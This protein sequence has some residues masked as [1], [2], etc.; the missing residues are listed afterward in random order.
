[1]KHHLAIFGLAV[2]TASG[3]GFAQQ[4][5]DAPGNPRGNERV[6]IRRDFAPPPP[7]GRRPPMER[8]F[9][10]MP[11]GGRWW[12]N[13]EIQ[14]KLN[15]T[16]D[17][18]KKMDDI[19]QQSRIKLIYMNAS[20]Q[21]AEVTLEPMMSSDQPDEA[22]IIAQIDKIAEARAELEKQNARMLL[23]LRSTLTLE[24][25]KKVQAIAPGPMM[26]RERGNVFYQK[27]PG[28]GGPGA[29]G[30]REDGLPPGAPR[31]PEE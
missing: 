17:Q 18:Q 31:P 10:I 3:L 15:L 25:W 4:T 6:I 29:G 26:D 5:P 9:R 7:E 30:L 12:A 14:Q 24:Q 16:V 8:S 27:M 22:K 13:P 2:C 1:M 21:E 19:F 20:L 11:L 28:P 23:G